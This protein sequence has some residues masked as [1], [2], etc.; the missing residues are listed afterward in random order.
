MVVTC[1]HSISDESILN[2]SDLH[3]ELMDELQQ[4]LHQSKLLSESFRVMCQEEPLDDLQVDNVIT[5][6]RSCPVS[7]ALPL[8]PSFPEDL[9]KLSNC[10]VY[11]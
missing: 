2:Y 3:P 1:L 4:S 10:V 9:N 6:M 11:F 5:L 8:L 7:S